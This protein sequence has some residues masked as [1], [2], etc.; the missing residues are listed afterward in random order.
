MSVS[1]PSILFMSSPKEEKERNLTVFLKFNVCLNFS[2]VLTLVYLSSE[3]FQY[4]LQVKA[5]K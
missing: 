1:V 4:L 2:N 5:I 3:M